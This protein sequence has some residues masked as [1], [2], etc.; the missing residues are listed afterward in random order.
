MGGA[1]NTARGRFSVTA[2]YLARTDADYSAAFAFNDDKGCLVDTPSTVGF[3][4]EKFYIN[5]IDI[6]ADFN[7]RQLGEAEVLAQAA[8]VADVRKSVE[9]NKKRLD[10]LSPTAD[11]QERAFATLDRIEA[12][13]AALTGDST[14]N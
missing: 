9:A 13:L 5:D 3:C 11:L 8:V 4:A 1:R 12:K 10:A 14:A 2:G 7:S 6:L